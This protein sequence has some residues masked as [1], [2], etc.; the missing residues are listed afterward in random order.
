MV[1]AGSPAAEAN[2][3]RSVADT[4]LRED[5]NM[6]LP[7]PLAPSIG[8]PIAALPSRVAFVKASSEERLQL[9]QRL[10]ANVFAYT[11]KRI[12]WSERFVELRKA[13]AESDYLAK[14]YAACVECSSSCSNS[15]DTTKIID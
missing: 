5:L 9:P 7:V 2:L 12:C 4:L 6:E 15:S 10:L 3:V 1:E 8:S 13:W 14:F 11:A